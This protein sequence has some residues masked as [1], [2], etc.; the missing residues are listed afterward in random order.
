M[1][2]LAES[3]IGQISV[4]VHDLQK[5]VE[6]Y[7]DKLELRLLFQVPPKLAFFDCGGVRLMLSLPEK[8][9]FDHPGSILY[10]KVPDIQDAYR[11]L[12]G[13]GVIFE[14]EPHSVARLETHDLWL[15]D[16]RDVDRN[17]LALMCEVAR[18]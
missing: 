5:A 15:C 2:A 3:K 4:N 13:R 16:F 9:E 11:T 8:P 18:S 7:R 6:F 17:L 14:A 12:K 10:F 1:A